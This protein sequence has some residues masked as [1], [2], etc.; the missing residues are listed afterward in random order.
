MHRSKSVFGLRKCM[1]ANAALHGYM[2]VYIPGD[3][4]LKPSRD[5]DIVMTSVS[6][7]YAD[8]SGPRIT[9]NGTWHLVLR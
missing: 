5:D 1:L 8:T 2:Q 3:N 4:G 9:W 7:A 6:T